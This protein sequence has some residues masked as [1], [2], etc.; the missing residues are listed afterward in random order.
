VELL[1]EQDAPF[2]AVMEGDGNGYFALCPELDVASQGQTI[3]EA[4]SSLVEALELFLE[5]ADPSE[6]ERRLRSDV[7]V[8]RVEVE[9]G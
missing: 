2:T 3:E 9:V 6:I 1:I 5:A 8:T 4:R 7:L